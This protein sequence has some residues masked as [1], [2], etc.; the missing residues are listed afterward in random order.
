MRIAF[1]A[2]LKSPDHPVP[3]GDREM[4]RLLIRAL[5]YSGHEVAT[6]S[7]LRTFAAQPLADRHA[8]ISAEAEAE[9]S[10]LSALF[11]ATG[12]PH[13]WL[14]Y[15][16]YY[17]APDLL[18]PRLASALGIPYV[19]AEAS[20]SERRDV[21]IWADTQATVA[22]AVKSA[23]LNICFTRRDRAGLERIAPGSRFA[24]LPPFID[25]S[26]FQAPA[27]RIRHGSSPW[28]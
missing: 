11:Q 22:A 3:S 5:E 21:G 14:S 24:M 28:R 18:G 13:L 26:M 7:H 15:H 12:K 20:Y 19:T 8:A 1:Y 17:K 27:P 6:A 23:A 9:I 16:P 10:R 4:A 25:T 2:P